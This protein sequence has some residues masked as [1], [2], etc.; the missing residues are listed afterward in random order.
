MA[1]EI[2]KE[3]LD[4]E[5]GKRLIGALNVELRGAYP[6]PGANH[7]RLDGEEVSEGSGAF[8]VAYADGMAVGAARCGNWTRRR[9]S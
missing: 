7:F 4:S 6:E 5:A 9:P 1:I 8:V 2:R 3:A